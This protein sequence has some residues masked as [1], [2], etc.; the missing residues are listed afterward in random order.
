[1]CYKL[2][3][4]F[5]R[6]HHIKSESLHLGALKSQL[7]GL[8]CDCVLDLKSPSQALYSCV[9]LQ[10]TTLD[11]F[12]NLFS[13]WTPPD[14]SATRQS[15]IL[16]PATHQQHAE[17]GASKPSRSCSGSCAAISRGWKLE[18]DEAEH[19]YSPLR[20]EVITAC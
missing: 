10:N 3:N 4:L 19:Q 7:V 14:K 8:S 12:L 9:D 20:L 5:P 15:V 6:F 18:E 17:L 11:G 1:M 16:S 2:L 13:P